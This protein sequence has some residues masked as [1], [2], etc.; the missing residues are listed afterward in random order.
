[1]NTLT[2]DTIRSHTSDQSFECGREYYQSGAI[3]DAIR[4]TV[5]TSLREGNT[6]LANCQVTYTYRLRVELDEG[7]I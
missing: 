3:Y 1:M 4:H 2:E 5:P 7:G 6:L